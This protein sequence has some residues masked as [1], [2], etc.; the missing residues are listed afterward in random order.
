MGTFFFD[1]P[2]VGG[3]TPG[4][5]ATAGGAGNWKVRLGEDKVGVESSRGR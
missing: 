3:A 2:G 4:V 5:D 1:G